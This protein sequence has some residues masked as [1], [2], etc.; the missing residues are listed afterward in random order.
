[1]FLFWQGIGSKDTIRKDTESSMGKKKMKWYTSNID[2]AMQRLPLITDPHS[3]LDHQQSKS[4]HYQLCVG[5]S[6]KHN[7]CCRFGF[8]YIP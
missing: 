6:R 5:C 3:F 2:G 4:E 8:G 7:G 1:M